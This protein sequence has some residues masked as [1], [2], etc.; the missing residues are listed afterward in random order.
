MIGFGKV[1]YQPEYA[2]RA[3]RILC[4]P[5]FLAVCVLCG[6]SHTSQKDHG[7]S[8]AAPIKHFKLDILFD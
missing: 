3:F 1:G 8:G 5:A 2:L 6:V 4:F 7:L